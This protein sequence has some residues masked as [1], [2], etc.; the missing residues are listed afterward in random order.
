MIARDWGE[1]TTKGNKETIESYGTFLYFDFESYTA[2]HVNL[3]EL[4]T[5][6]GEFHCKCKFKKKMEQKEGPIV[7]P[8]NS[9]YSAVITLAYF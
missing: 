8:A 2:V 6:I 5:K 4:H 9:T 7:P 3:A 1:V